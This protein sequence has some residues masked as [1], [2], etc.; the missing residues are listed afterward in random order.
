[1]EAKQQSKAEQENY[2]QCEQSAE[3]GCRAQQQGVLEKNA[4]ELA[5]NLFGWLGAV[6]DT[7]MQSS[8]PPAWHVLEE[9]EDEYVAPRRV[10]QP[11]KATRTT[12][13]STTDSP[14]SSP[15]STASDQARSS[16]TLSLYKT[17]RRR[18]G[19][20]PTVRPV[21]SARAPSKEN[22]DDEVETYQI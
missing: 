9:H 7:V 19:R 18:R 10:E 11:V 3:D 6:T 5:R 8:P 4:E 12:S 22:D 15:D 14:K 21:H 16:R 2:L 20:S 13:E 1:M 17:G